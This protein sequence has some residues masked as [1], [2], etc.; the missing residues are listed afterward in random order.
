MA[1]RHGILIALG[2]LA[3]TAA[4]P[5]LGESQPSFVGCGGIRPTKPKVEP[6]F[7]ISNGEFTNLGFECQMWQ[8]FI[9]VNWPAQPGLRGVPN[10]QAPFGATGPTV[11]ETYKTIDQVFLPG[12]ANPGSWDVIKHPAT[13]AAK[14]SAQVS[15]GSLRVLKMDSKVSRA[16]LANVARQGASLDPTVLNAITQAAGG[17]LY[18]LAGNPVYYEVAMNRDEYEYIVQNGLYNA[19]TQ[20]T[21]AQTTDIVLPSGKTQYGEYGALEVKAAWKILNAAEAKSGRFH[22]VQALIQGTSALAPA[23][24]VGLVGFHM[25]LPNIGQGVWATFAQIDNAPVVPITGLPITGTYN[26]YNTKCGGCP[27]NVENANPGQV[28]QMQP[29]DQSTPQLNAYMQAQIKLKAPKS[30]WQYYKIVNIQWSQTT[31]DIGKI[32]A[33]SIKPLPYGK[34]PND[35]VLN[36]V[37]ETFIQ[38]PGNSCLA[39]HRTA[40]IASTAANPPM[41]AYSFVFGAA[42]T[43]PSNQQLPAKQ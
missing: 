34:P 15:S 4:T 13:L 3:L 21:F 42:Q 8:N 1:V 18:D 6:I 38:Q 32:P 20:A 14:L 24:T 23:V 12:A 17:T 7:Q 5:A 28:M 16:V 29:D 33:P 43:P 10:K 31:D 41:T 39:C 35:T 30:P 19:N 2:A 22:T 37:L 27:V 26:F 36:P 25:Y 9:Y 11:W 40:T